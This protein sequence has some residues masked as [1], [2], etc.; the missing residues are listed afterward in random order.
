M[1]DSIGQLF[2]F[3][4]IPSIGSPH[5]ITCYATYPLEFDNSANSNRCLIVIKRL[6]RRHSR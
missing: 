2:T 5:K 6:Y 4:I 1:L 3:G